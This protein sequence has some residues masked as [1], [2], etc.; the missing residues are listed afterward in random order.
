VIIV[1][2]TWRAILVVAVAVA[3]KAIFSPPAPP[4]AA[5]AWQPQP[6]VYVQQYP[7]YGNQ[8]PVHENGPIRRVG[9]ATVELAEAVLGV[10]R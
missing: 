7:V 6:Q 5:V 10:I 8:T 9:Q 3:L 2:D 4:P 1:R